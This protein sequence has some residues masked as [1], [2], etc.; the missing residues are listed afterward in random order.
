[1]KVKAHQTFSIRMGWLYKGISNVIE[2]TNNNL[3][4]DRFS[5]LFISENSMNRLG[6][7]SAMVKSLRYW[8][9]AT[10]LTI[11]NISGNRKGQKA[12]EFGYLVYKYDKHFEEIGTLL[13]CHYF[14]V[15]DMEWGTSWYY[16]FN[17]FNAREFTK[18]DLLLET[19]NWIHSKKK[20]V[21]ESSIA[22]DIDCIIK[23]YCNIHDTEYEG[24]IFENNKICPFSQ[25]GLISQSTENPSIYY[26]NSK[27]IEKI[28]LEIAMFVIMKQ[29]EKL[30]SKNIQSLNLDALILN[31][32]SLSKVFNLTTEDLIRLITKLEIE[33]Y[34]RYVK[35]AGLEQ[36]IISNVNNNSSYYLY[37][38]YEKRKNEK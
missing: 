34:L 6:L 36:I 17:E 29:I 12:T 14:L 10:G 22:S 32:A 3:N 1:M 28:P 15:S 27:F 18:N 24:N 30:N 8:M 25:L 21:A 2:D 35:T 7:G 11:E 26:K 19:S 13:L 5:D 33:G 37:Q 23:S 38:Y 4:E 31:S 16:F 9:V 20:T